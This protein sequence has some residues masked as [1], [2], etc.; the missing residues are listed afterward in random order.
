MFRYSMFVCSLDVQISNVCMFT[1]TSDIQCLYD[2]EKFGYPMFVC[3]LKV[4]ISNVCM[5]TKSSDIQC[6]YVH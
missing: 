5:L 3:L 2:H 1:R 6:L 4:Q